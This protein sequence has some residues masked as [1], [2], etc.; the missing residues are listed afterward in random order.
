MTW[1][2]PKYPLTDK[3]MKKWYP[4]ITEYY[5]VIKENGPHERTPRPRRGGYA[6]EGGPRGATP[7]SRSG[8]A[9]VRRYPSSKVRSSGCALLEQL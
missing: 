8:G 9:A 3:E 5:I 4:Y 2:Q 7:H 1:K 6:G